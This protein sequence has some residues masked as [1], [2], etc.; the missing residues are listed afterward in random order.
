MKASFLAI[1]LSLNSIPLIAMQNNNDQ[2]VSVIVVAIPVIDP[3][4]S[5][6]IQQLA[7][8]NQELRVQN[9]ALLNDLSNMPREQHPRQQPVQNEE[10]ID[11]LDFYCPI[12]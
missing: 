8:E 6:T 12:Q 7:I 10:P 11:I 9:Q 5:R 4:S 3:A 1:A 2:R